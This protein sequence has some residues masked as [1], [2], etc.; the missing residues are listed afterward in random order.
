LTDKHVRF[1]LD[2]TVATQAPLVPEIT[3]TLASLANCVAMF[4]PKHCVMTISV[5]LCEGMYCLIHD[6]RVGALIRSSASSV[7]CSVA[8]T[9]WPPMTACS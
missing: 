9:P 4:P 5:L 3:L 8:S 1:V 2:N 7:V 6:S